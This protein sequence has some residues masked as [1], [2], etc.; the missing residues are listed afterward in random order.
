MN[1]ITLAELVKTLQKLLE[2]HGDCAVYI[3]TDEYRPS[4]LELNKVYYWEF[5]EAVYLAGERV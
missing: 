1:G 5:E 3:D 4:T 2:E